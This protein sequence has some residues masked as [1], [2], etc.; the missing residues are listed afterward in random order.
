MDMRPFT[1]LKFRTMRVDT[2]DERPPRL[3]RADDERRAPRPAGTGST[4]ST[5]SDGH[6][7]RPLAAA[8]EPRRAAA[9][10]QRPARRHVARRPSPVHRSTRPST[11][12]RTTSS[13]PGA[14]GDHGALAGDGARPRHVRR[15]TGHGRRLRARLVARPRPPAPAAA[16]R[17]RSF[18][19]GQPPDM[20]SSLV[21]GDPPAARAQPYPPVA[22]RRR[23]PRLLGAQPR[24]QPRRAPRRR[25]RRGVRPR[26]DA[27]VKIGAALSRRADRDDVDDV[28]ARTSIEAVAIATPVSTHYPLALRRAR[29]RQARLRREAARRARSSEALDLIAA[30][31]ERRP[32]ADARPHV[33]LQPAGELH[34]RPDPS[35]RA[36][37]DLLHLDEPGQPRAA[38]ADA[39]WPGTSAP[40]TSRSCAT[41]SRRRRAT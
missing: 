31:R 34:P 26:E 41:G 1:V 8:D 2:D 18:D 22:R 39:A 7:G 16:R 4:S 10:P 29:R 6:A 15:G 14:A 33:P 32:R 25:S 23:R 17:S 37:R 19:R 5:A 3:H 30:A 21:Q 36:R 13:V 12:S 24:P 40:T 9:A 28:L 27:L 20:P 38:P 11:S 35:G